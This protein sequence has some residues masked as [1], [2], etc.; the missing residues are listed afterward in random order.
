VTRRIGSL[1][2]TRAA[3]VAVALLVLAS[4]CGG[5]S[6]RDPRADQPLQ[7]MSTTTA[8]PT[9]APPTDAELDA[10]LIASYRHNWETLM[11]AYLAS[12]VVGLHR[13]TSGPMLYGTS[14][15]ILYGVRSGLVWSATM[16]HH[17]RVEE[18]NEEW[19]A[20]HDCLYIEDAVVDSLSEELL[21]E[22]HEWVELVVDLVREDD[23]WKL[24]SW[25]LL[26]YGCQPPAPQI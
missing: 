23:T 1:R 2:T 24:Y 25:E 19:A 5:T 3:L 22:G 20:V 13:I 8:P 7:G 18:R 17:P 15:E 26:G 14:D 12:S 6:S 11:H 4:A 9:T 10:E 21:G 16:Q